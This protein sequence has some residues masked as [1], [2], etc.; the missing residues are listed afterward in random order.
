[1]KRSEIAVLALGLAL[2]VGGAWVLVE[3]SLAPPPVPAPVGQVER[4]LALPGLLALATV[5]VASVSRLQEQIQGAAES[6]A[7]ADPDAERS[8][9]DTILEQAGVDVRRDVTHLSAALY[10]KDDGGVGTGAALF[11]RFDAAAL[12]KALRESPGARVSDGSTAGTLRVF[13]LDRESCETSEPWSVQL[14]ADRILASDPALMPEIAARLA[15]GAAPERDLTRFERYRDGQLASAAFFVPDALPAGIGNPMVAMPAE[16]VRQ[17]LDGFRAVYL[18][19]G[20]R[21][22]PARATLGGLIESPDP[23][24]AEALEA[25]MRSAIEASRT[26]LESLPTLARLHDALSLGSDGGEVALEFALDSETARS[27]EALPGEVMGLMFGGLAS[28][29]SFGGGQEEAAG[30]ERLDEQ[31]E[32]FAESYSSSELAAYDPTRDFAGPVD[33]ISGPFGFRLE[34]VSLPNDPES[35]G[36]EIVLDVIGT[37]IRNLGERSGRARLT[38]A[39]AVDAGG[40]ELLAEEACGRDRNDRPVTLSRSFGTGMLQGTKKV[41]LRHDVRADDVARLS[42]NVSLRLPLRTRSVVLS[43]PAQGMTAEA[44]GATIEL[45]EVGPRQISYRERGA[46]SR[47]LAVRALNAERRPLASESATSV[48]SPFGGGRSRTEGFAGHIAH[49]EVVFAVEEEELEFPFELAGLR[50]GTAGEHLMSSDVAFEDAPLRNIVRRFQDAL[51]AQFVDGASVQ[52][53][54]KTGPF[55]VTL[56]QMWAFGGLMPR[57]GVYA[58]DLPNLE[59]SM[60][61][62]EITLERILLRDGTLRTALDPPDSP[63]FTIQGLGEQSAPEWSQLLAMDPAFGREGTLQGV[64]SLETGANIDAAEVAALE[65]S[66]ILRMPRRIRTLSMDAVALGARTSGGGISIELSELGR[67][68]FA[69]RSHGAG[70]RVLA[71]RAFNATGDELWMTGA[72]AEMDEEGWK[73]SF[74]VRGVPARIEII[75]AGELERAEY[76]YALML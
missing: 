50:P 6:D 23:A 51:D 63:A 54:T 1:M 42:G 57:F 16:M 19:A 5:D 48:G 26:K 70:E 72:E 9:L 28:S 53:A 38:V 44:A 40:N 15:S 58:P 66:L 73:G 52:A 68:A 31:A 39:S 49:V 75:T 4:A 34:S 37:G 56:E 55:V 35:A 11:G 8:A 29:M 30:P 71:V 74:E 2:V 14:G 59:N 47:V 60:S 25:R 13:L 22:L 20:F 27:L 10:V 12:E 18:R 24:T 64:A 3:R 61:A 45:T 32:V 7:D 69:L 41:R 46:V 33:Q 36:P 76:R 67:D 21:A 65:G 17:Q 43:E 62:L